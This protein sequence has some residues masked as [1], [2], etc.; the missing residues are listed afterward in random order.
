MNGNNLC[1][2]ILSL[3]FTEDTSSYNPFG[4]INGTII[5]K[6]K[7]KIIIEV[8]NLDTDDTIKQEID[9]NDFVFNQLLPGNYEIWAYENINPIS[10]NYF[11]GTLEPLKESA[12]FIIYNKNLYV[13][14]N[15][16]NTI[17][18]ELK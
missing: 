4:E 8:I 13:R 18:M 1:D 14:P 7:H 16:S 15:W 9:D 2:T 17:S 11:S 5:Y 3:N 12:K 10:N 6:G